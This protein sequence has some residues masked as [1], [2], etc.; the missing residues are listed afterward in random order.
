MRPTRPTWVS[1]FFTL[2]P[3]LWAATSCSR[4]EPPLEERFC[5]WRGGTLYQDLCTMWGLCV[6]HTRSPEAALL[7]CPSPPEGSASVGGSQHIFP[8]LRAAYFPSGTRKQPSASQ[9]PISTPPVASTLVPCTSKC[10][11]ATGRAAGPLVNSLHPPLFPELS[12]G[13]FGACRW[14]PVMFS[15]S[16]AGSQRQS[17]PS[18]SSVSWLHVLVHFLSNLNAGLCFC[19][20]ELALCKFQLSFPP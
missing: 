13:V 20:G 1:V 7:C 18:P 16:G 10:A 11:L 19:A 15:L 3:P 8:F 4:A 17:C 14:L 2:L 12:V 9:L 5:G 6:P